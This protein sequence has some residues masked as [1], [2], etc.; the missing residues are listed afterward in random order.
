MKDMEENETKHGSVNLGIG[1]FDLLPEAQFESFW[2]TLWLRIRP[3]VT[4]KRKI[5]ASL[6]G[7]SY[8]RHI[9]K[10]ENI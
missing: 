3:V 2:D 9:K 8:C 5:P 6:I 7:C 4:V 1:K 10:I